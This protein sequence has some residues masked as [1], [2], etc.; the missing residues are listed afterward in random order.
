MENVWH[1]LR[2]NTLC[3]RVWD[4]YEDIVDAC[5]AAWRFLIDDPAR[6]RSIGNR[7]WACVNL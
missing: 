7:K 4:S 5:S 2:E 1:Y 3:S 6:I